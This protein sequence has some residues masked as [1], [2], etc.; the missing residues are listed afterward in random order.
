MRD[1]GDAKTHPSGR[2]LHLLHSC[3]GEGRGLIYPVLLMAPSHGPYTRL[4]TAGRT[5]A[6]LP[7]FHMP[8]SFCLPSQSSWKSCGYQAHPSPAWHRGARPFM[9]SCSQKPVVWSPQ[10]GVRGATDSQQIRGNLFPVLVCK[11]VL[12]WASSPFCFGGFVWPVSENVPG[13][14]SESFIW[15]ARRK[16]IKK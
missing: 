16:F 11:S 3:L 9:T 15:S 10:P 12:M 1:C 13:L 6:L 2:V 5:S 4:E 7:W 8:L 14:L